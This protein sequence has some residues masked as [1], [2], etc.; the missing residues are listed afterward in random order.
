MVKKLL[1]FE[2]SPRPK[3]PPSRPGIGLRAGYGSSIKKNNLDPS[4]HKNFEMQKY[5]QN[6]ARC[7][8]VNSRNDL[9][10]RMKLQEMMI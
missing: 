7:N 9:P 6:E 3:S 8:G 4:H 5:Y 2:S 1:Q 10:E